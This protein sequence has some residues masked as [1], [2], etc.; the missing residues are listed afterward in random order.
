M[1]VC[2]LISGESGSSVDAATGRA[3]LAAEVAPLSADRSEPAGPYQGR[4]RSV[5][6]QRRPQD[7]QIRRR[8]DAD[9]ARPRT[10]VERRGETVTTG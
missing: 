6:G 9:A 3:P 4:E 5:H 1:V 8:V 10:D 7:G 2:Q